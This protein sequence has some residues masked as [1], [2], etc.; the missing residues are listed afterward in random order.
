MTTEIKIPSVGESIQEGMIEAW[1][2]NN[3]DWVEVD[4]VLLELE[5]DKAT[6]EVVAESA[7]VLE[8][9]KEEGSV[10]K[11]GEL[12]GIISQKNKRPEAIKQQE[13]KSPDNST[14]EKKHQKELFSHQKENNGPAVR[15][16]LEENQVDTANIP[17]T[18]L[19]NRI[20][21]NDVL[22]VLSADSSPSSQAI[23]KPQLEHQKENKVADTGRLST[24]TPMSMIR[25]RIS[26]RLLAAQSESAILTTFNEVDMT[27]INEMRAKYKEHFHKRYQVKLGFMGFFLKASVAALEEYTLVN[28]Y[29]EKHEIVSHNYCDIGVA[30]ST[31]KGL[32]VPIIRNVEKLS[33]VQIEEQITLFSE[34]ARNNKITLDDLKGGTFTVSNGGIFGSLMSTPILNPPQSAILGMHKV[35]MR[36]VVSPEGAIEAKP[37]MYLALSYDH[38]IIDGKEAVGFLKKIKEC[39]EDPCRLIIG[40]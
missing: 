40:V 26:E 33:I 19:N 16:L 38:R 6:V 24:R 20:T 23:E 12:V 22:Q 36:P 25:R 15:R 39:L 7:G 11:V 3:G 29:I 27:A 35:Q 28:S 17:A 14:E 10:V 18:G 8:I 21:K 31:E 32:M 5:T 13:I 30:V 4:D 34:K 9:A 37:M 1:H 2:K